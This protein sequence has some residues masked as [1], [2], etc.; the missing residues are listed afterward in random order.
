MNN[1]LFAKQV[2]QIASLGV[3]QVTTGL[4]MLKAMQPTDDVRWNK[5]TG[6]FVTLKQGLHVRGS[7]G[8]L[9][10]STTLQE[11]LFDAGQSAAT[12]DHRFTPV[13]SDEIKDIGIEVTLIEDVHKVT[14]ADDVVVGKHGLIISQ[15]DKRGVLLPGVAFEQK[16]TSEQFLEATCEKANLPLDSWKDP[17]TL[18][19]IFTCSIF[20]APEL[21]ETIREFVAMDPTKH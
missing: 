2:L 21:F 19:E 1:D 12:H 13:A 8:L 20:E 4:P 5:K 7:V 14:K 6:V 10:S 18:V 17:N 16:W 9:E 11:A 3:W 15:G